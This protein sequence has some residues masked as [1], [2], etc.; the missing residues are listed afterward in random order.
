M[1]L[2]NYHKVRQI[3]QKNNITVAEM[4]NLLNLKSVY[5]YYKKEQGVRRF[6]LEEARKISELFEMDIDDIFFENE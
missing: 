6:S 1:I 3:R 2:I 4:A 5:A